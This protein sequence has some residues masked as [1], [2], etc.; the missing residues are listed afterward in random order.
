MGI[1]GGVRCVIVMAWPGHIVSCRCSDQTCSILEIKNHLQ[2]QR[3]WIFSTMHKM[4]MHTMHNAI[5]REDFVGKHIAFRGPSIIQL[6]LDMCNDRMIQCFHFFVCECVCVLCPL[7]LAM[8]FEHADTQTLSHMQCIRHIGI[9]LQWCVFTIHFL[10]FLFCARVWML[11]GWLAFCA[12]NIYIHD[13]Y[14]TCRAQSV[15]WIRCCRIERT[16]FAC[17]MVVKHDKQC[18]VQWRF[19]SLVAPFTFCRIALRVHLSR[20]LAPYCCWLKNL[21]EW[22]FGNLSHE[23]LCL[24][25]LLSSILSAHFALCHGPF[26]HRSELHFTPPKHCRNWTFSSRT[27]NTYT[28]V[29]DNIN[30]LLSFMVTFWRT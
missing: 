20:Q 8:F 11:V 10:V 2:L 16:R 28:W 30:Y 22:L 12:M 14:G 1:H 19:S 3:R 6:K 26:Y 23:S 5:A 27:S 17:V 13:A 15:E 7:A 21:A 29:I 4:H 24:Y 25:I 18:T 9:A